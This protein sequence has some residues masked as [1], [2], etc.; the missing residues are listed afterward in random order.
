MINYTK[1]Q[2]IMADKIGKL[3]VGGLLAWW[4]IHSIQVGC[5]SPKEQAWEQS[6]YKAED[7]Y[8]RAHRPAREGFMRWLKG[9]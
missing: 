5:P 9:P 4:I 1:K 3:I 8:N 7:D 6:R 2:G